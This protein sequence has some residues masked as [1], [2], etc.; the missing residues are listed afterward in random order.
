MNLPAVDISTGMVFHLATSA[1]RA[2]AVAA[3]A[4]ACLTLF[5][6]RSTSA[7]LFTWTVVLYASLALAIVGW[8]LPALS[9]KMPAFLGALQTAEKTKSPNADS[10]GTDSLLTTE[11]N[12][13]MH[14]SVVV[15]SSPNTPDSGLQ[16]Q[17]PP[18]RASA[19]EGSS[20]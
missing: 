20:F 10:S 4:G 9:I 11:A 2:I 19:Q 1:L 16:P 12:T 8:I 7:R 5:R 18:R 6:V 17:A 13:E 14:A 3:G 15:R